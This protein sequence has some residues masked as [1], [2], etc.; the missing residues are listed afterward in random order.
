MEGRGGAK[1]KADGAARAR[2]RAG[3][4][5]PR[6][7]PHTRRTNEFGFPALLHHVTVDLLRW[8]LHQLERRA[9]AGADGVTWDQ[10]KAGLERV[11]LVDLHGRVHRGA[12]RAKPPDGR[13]RPLSITALEGKIVQRAVM[14]ILNT[15]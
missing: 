4:P 2:R 13:Q 3:K 9:A 8:S 5:I 6:A 11:N 15:I 12:Y 7:G 10:Y 1:G 14:E